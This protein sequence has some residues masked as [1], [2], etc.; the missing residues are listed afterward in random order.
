VFLS[1][2]LGFVRDL[3]K[4]GLIE[5]DTV[6]AYAR[7][8]LVLVVN[9]ESGVTVKDLA[10]LARPEVKRVAIANPEVAPYGLAAKQALQKAGLWD[11][12]QPKLAQA[13]T[14]RQALQ[15][16][17]MGNAEAGLVAHSVVSVPEV[18]SSDVPPELYEPILQG[19]GVVAG[20][21]HR[22]A[23][24]Q[25]TQFLLDGEGQK[26]LLSHGFAPAR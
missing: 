21:A 1:A 26:I 9:R 4:E 19:L 12:L 3:A 6:S 14:V 17:Q 18:R 13:E 8:R 22:D 16:V 11:R 15:Y 10:G 2:N 24:R 5:P 25:F 23:A 7:G 20:S